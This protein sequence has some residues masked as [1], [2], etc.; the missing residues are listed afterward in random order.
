KLDEL[1]ANIHEHGV[2]QAIRVRPMGDRLELV[3]GERR[4]RAARLAGKTL[5]PATVVSMTDLEVIDAQ[6]TENSQREDI[7]PIEEADGY[8]LRIEKT[9][10]QPKEIAAIVGRHER[11][12]WRR[13]LLGKLREKG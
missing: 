3:F 6:L 12:V 2:L 13:V 4:V 10:C 5:I 1:A 8:V 11:H 7:D 9:G